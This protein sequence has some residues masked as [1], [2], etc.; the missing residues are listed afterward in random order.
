ME[1]LIADKGMILVNCQAI[2]DEILATDDLD[3]KISRLQDQASGLS[4]RIRRLVTENANAVMDQ[5]AFE[6]DYELLTWQYEAL[7]IKIEATQREKADKALRAKR[8]KLFIHML[9]AQE[10]RSDFD[11]LLFTGLVDKVV[12][13][14]EKKK[15]VLTFILRDG[16]DHVITV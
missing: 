14:G 9:Q 6:K 4:Q 16:S 15:V 5:T 12:V 7:T 8:V 3:Q 13:S 11:P 1:R 2:L 10:E